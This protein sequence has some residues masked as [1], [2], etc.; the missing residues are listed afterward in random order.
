MSES[1]CVCVCV[2]GYITGT[3]YQV[4]FARWKFSDEWRIY[5]SFQCEINIAYRKFSQTLPFSENFPCWIF[6]VLT[7]AVNENYPIYCICI[8][9]LGVTCSWIG[10]S[11]LCNQI[12]VPKCTRFAKEIMLWNYIKPSLAGG[13]TATNGHCI[14]LH[15]PIQPTSSRWCKL[16]VCCKAWQ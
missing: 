5:K 2:C 4:I 15:V 8:H 9:I 13:N 7:L 3:V 10:W 16:P 6:L 12:P 14:P 11:F 1:V